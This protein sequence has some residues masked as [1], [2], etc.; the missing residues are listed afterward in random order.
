M[1]WSHENCDR[2]GAD[3]RGY[4][5][6]IMRFLL[7]ISVVGTHAGFPFLV[8]GPRAVQ[9]FYMISGF[10]ISYVLL[11]TAKYPRV[12][13]FYISRFLRLWPVYAVVT[14]LTALAHL[15]L[16]TGFF[17]RLFD[18]PAQA[19][20][21]LIVSNITLFFQDWVMFLKLDGDGFALITRLGEDP[22][23]IWVG[24]LNAPAWS[25]GVEMSF[26]L[27]APFILHRPKLLIGLL[28][29]S[30]A[31]RGLFIAQGFG[32]NDPWRYRFFPTELAFFILGALAHQISAR[33][34]W[35][36]LPSPGWDRVAVGLFVLGLIVFPLSKMLAYRVE[37]ILTVVLYG[38]FL[39]ALPTLFRFQNAHR[40]DGVLGELSY[41]IYICHWFVLLLVREAWPGY[42][43]Q[44]FSAWGETWN[45]AA[46]WLVIP[47][48]IL[49][50]WA[51]NETVGAGVERFR[52]RFRHRAA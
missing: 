18:Q 35:G 21:L 34:R 11:D 17:E 2:A 24:L 38:A 30:L 44:G 14:A 33:T 42:Q 51:I 20:I 10:L 26:Y 22:D 16:G 28:V 5:M 36:W 50:A 1:A 3:F 19:Q 23:P 7:A 40:W 52:A 32:M 37:L 25:L 43:S 48:V 8:G 27:I 49:V 46:L 12:L 29:A 9:V 15:A 31:L 41:P 4:G 45:V 39:I 47:L 13:P 6:G